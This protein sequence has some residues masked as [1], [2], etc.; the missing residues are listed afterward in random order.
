MG[1][2]I[3]REYDIRGV[4]DRDLTSPIVQGLGRGLGMMLRQPGKTGPLRVAVGRD[5]RLS[6]PRIVEDL[7]AGL[8]KA[9]ANV[10]D[11]GVGPTPYLYFAAHHL[12]TD[13]SVMV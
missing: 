5:C 7:V 3:Y 1:K 4:A 2:H 11:I 9:G 8:R 13:G 6:G 12:G 10:V